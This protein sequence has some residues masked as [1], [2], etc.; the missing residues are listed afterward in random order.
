MPST[1]CPSYLRGVADRE[2][3]APKVDITSTCCTSRVCSEG[4]GR[5]GHSPKSICI[6]EQPMLWIARDELAR[7]DVAIPDDLLG[8]RLRRTRTP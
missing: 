8:D 3:V 6:L 5:L 2:R 7:E 4:S 1:N